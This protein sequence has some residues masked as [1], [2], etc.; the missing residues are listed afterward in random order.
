MENPPKDD[1]LLFQ[2]EMVNWKLDVGKS[3]PC[4]RIRLWREASAEGCRASVKWPRS[5]S[6]IAR[7]TLHSPAIK[8]RQVF[9]P[10]SKTDMTKKPSWI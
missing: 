3:P 4:R 10:Q 1:R 5:N 2:I 6:T 8:I 9:I 7:T